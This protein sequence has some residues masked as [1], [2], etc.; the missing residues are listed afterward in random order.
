MA[1]FSTIAMTAV[2]A[3]SLPQL[4]TPQQITVAYIAEHAREV[5]GIG[6]GIMA[7][8]L[9]LAVALA[10][11]FG[12][13]GLQKSPGVVDETA[14]PATGTVAVAVARK[15][16]ASPRGAPALLLLIVWGS[17]NLQPTDAPCTERCSCM[18]C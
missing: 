1:L 14:D 18:C 3:L 10:A 17:G 15:H 11:V 13:A 8:G 2:D 9:L 16:Q 7:T 6:A 4:P 5:A 12:N